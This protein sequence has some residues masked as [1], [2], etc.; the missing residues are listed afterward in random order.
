MFRSV[1]Y[2]CA[3]LAVAGCTQDDVT[4]QNTQVAAVAVAAPPR[5]PTVVLTSTARLA[6]ARE[7]VMHK[8]MMAGATLLLAS[9]QSLAPD[10]TPLGQVEAKVVVPPG[11]GRPATIITYRSA[12]GFTGED[13]AAVQIVF[14]DG[15]APTVVFHIDVE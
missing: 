15:D 2:A 11:H 1:I 14:P 12:A 7:I 9:P 5:A 4:I 10:C 8:T 13:S 6:K 3:C